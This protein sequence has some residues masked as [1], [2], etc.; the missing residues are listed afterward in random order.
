M[1]L[2]R[3]RRSQDHNYFVPLQRMR[4]HINRLFDLP[5]F[6]GE[7]LLSSWVPSIDFQE[8]KDEMIVRAE[9]P[10]MRKEDINVSLEENQLLISGE[11]RCDMNEGASKGDADA[12]ARHSEC[13]YGR[14]QRSIMLPYAVDQPKITANYKDGILTVHL[15]RSEQAK[16][17]QIQVSS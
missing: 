2:T 14:F 11:K 12:G 7:N 10:G 6:P 9:L 13:F 8:G 1:Q 16:P 15:P 5:E 4:E 3:S 17:K